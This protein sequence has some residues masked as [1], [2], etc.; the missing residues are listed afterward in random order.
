MRTLRDRYHNDP[1]FAALVKLMVSHIQ[2]GNFTPSEM[3]EAS[4]LASIIYEERNI[5]EM[6][7]VE[8]KV[9]EALRI[10]RDRVESSKEATK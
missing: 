1:Q 7:F 8:P 9:E 3:R 10:I 4:M 2:Q 6:V 5:R